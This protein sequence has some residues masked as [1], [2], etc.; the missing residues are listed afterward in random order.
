LQC[1]ES[2]RRA[3]TT[4]HKLNTATTTRITTTT[5]T[6]NKRRNATT[7]S[8]GN[9]YISCGRGQKGIRGWVEG[10]AYTE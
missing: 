10:G 7:K 1:S 9:V 4:T 5:T 8:F 2:A 3:T 6:T